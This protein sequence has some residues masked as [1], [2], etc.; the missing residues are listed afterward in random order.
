MFNFSQDLLTMLYSNFVPQAL[1]A[2]LLRSL[3]INCSLF[4]IFMGCCES[5]PQ[6]TIVVVEQFG[7]FHYLGEP[8]LLCLPVPCICSNA[9]KV[10]LRVQQLNVQTE[11]KTSDNGEFFNS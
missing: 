7:K 11:T 9:G 6:D 8:G 2:H 5:V 10:N 3:A 1:V 4:S